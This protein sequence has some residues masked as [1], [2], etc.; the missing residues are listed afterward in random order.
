MKNTEYNIENTSC[1]CKNGYT[2]ETFMESFG[3]DDAELKKCASCSAY[4]YDCGIMTC[5]KFSK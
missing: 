1:G 5:S 4:E 2:E 3:K